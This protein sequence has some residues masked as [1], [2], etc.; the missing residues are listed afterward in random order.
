M[1]QRPQIV[2]PDLYFFARNGFAPQ[3]VAE[4][5]QDPRIHLVTPDD[6]L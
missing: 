6:L 5:E 2:L 1:S 4:A 3:L